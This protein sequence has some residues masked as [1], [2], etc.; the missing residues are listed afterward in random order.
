MPKND[1]IMSI[2]SG[3]QSCLAFVWDEKGQ[4]LAEGRAE[5]GIQAP[6]L[7]WFEQDAGAWWTA[8]CSSIRQVLERIDVDRIGFLCIS[9][10]RE[11]FVPVDLD[12]NPLRPAMLH[13]DMRSQRQVRRVIE[14]LGSE[15]VQSIT[16]KYPS[17]VSSLYKILWIMENEPLVADKVYKYMDVHGFLLKHLIG[18]YVTSDVSAD[19]MALIDLRTR[20]WSAE[21]M[22]ALG[23]QREQF[24]DLC[25]PGKVVGRITRSASRATGLLEGLPVVAGAGDGICAALGTR[26]TRLDRIF[27]YIGTWTVLGGFSTHYVVD[28]AFRTLLGVIPGSYHLEA[29]VAGGYIVSWFLDNYGKDPQS[30][31]EEYWE[32]AILDIPPGSKGLLTVPYWFGALAPYWDNA[33]RGITLGWTGNHT[34]GHMYRSI[35]EGV[36]F[37]HR[38]L[39][40]AMAAALKT[41]YRDVTFV[42]GGAK[43]RLWGQITSD[44]FGLPIYTTSTVESSVLG[45]AIIGAACMGMYSSIQEASEK[46]TNLEMNYRP[47]GQNIPIYNRF[48]EVYKDIFPALQGKIQKLSEIS[49]QTEPDTINERSAK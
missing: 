11:T 8:A 36:A 9:H 19:P 3:T 22:E 16:G 47:N 18:E 17:Y 34:C 49:Q 21:L 30:R 35:L 27:F 43:S 37:E 14:Q 26:T 45:A 40:E 1:L 31:S 28:R 6:R 25:E 44:V 2:D 46:M 29:N 42:G 23:L 48:F 38:M 33:S 7:G 15:R 12:C 41:K 32:K 4:A 5:H 13:M 24:L 39:L 20:T 10:Q